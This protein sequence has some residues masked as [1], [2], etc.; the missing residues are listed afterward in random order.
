MLNE[1]QLQGLFVPVVTPFLPSE[2]LDLE[3]FERIISH[4]LKHRIQGIV[5]NGTT[6]ESPT[7]S[8]NE[9]SVMMQTLVSIQQRGQGDGSVPIVVGVGTND[10]AASVKRAEL[11]ANMGADAVLVVTPYYSRPSLEGIVRHYGRI[12]Q[13]GVPVI[14][15]EIPSRTGVK[16]DAD[17]MKRI[18]DINGLIGLK[19]STGSTELVSALTAG[20]DNK[21][22]LCGDDRL[23][24]AMLSQGASGGML[25]SANVETDTFL[26][27]YR[28]AA[29][30]QYRESRA[31]FNRLTP[32][33]ELLFR[34]SNPAPIKWLLKQ[35]GLLASDTLRLP[36]API[37]EGLRN[38]MERLQLERL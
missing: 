29:A 34:E 27:V 8:W 10:T 33:I 20:G 30:G 13:V 26:E 31:I 7:V 19:D 22:V 36:M 32:L 38:E 23:F 14:A 24:H 3:S 35:Q 2:E 6:G 11:A 4:L 25:A 17:T 1:L 5:L 9:V 21:P 18:L 16:V 15:Y 28:L 12:A 37:T